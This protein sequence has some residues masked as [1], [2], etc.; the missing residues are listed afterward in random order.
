MNRPARLLSLNS[1]HYRRG[2]SDAVYL[3]HD[4]L[5]H[6]NGW[7]TASF[8]MKHKNN[9]DS[10]WSKYFV[11]ELEFGSDYTITQKIQMAG[12]VIYSFEARRKIQKIQ[13]QK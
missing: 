5:F 9:L 6:E 11:D 1:Y 10:Q 12:K 3:E 2:G 8:S 7:Q 4:S 13:N